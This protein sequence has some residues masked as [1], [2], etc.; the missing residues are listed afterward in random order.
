[1]YYIIKSFYNKFLKSAKISPTKIFGDQKMPNILSSY[2]G[3]HTEALS[4]EQ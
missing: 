1:M 4:S 2:T 3:E